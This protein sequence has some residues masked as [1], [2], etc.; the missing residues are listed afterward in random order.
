[1]LHNGFNNMGFAL[2]FLPYD[3][4]LADR[5]NTLGFGLNNQNYT[6]DM[7]DMYEEFVNEYIKEIEAGNVPDIS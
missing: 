6:K 1:L 5:I 3:K 4:S 2:N 7:Y